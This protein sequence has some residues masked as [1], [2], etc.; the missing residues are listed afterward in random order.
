MSPSLLEAPLSE[1]EDSDFEA[2]PIAF[3]DVV[4]R[5]NTAETSMKLENSSED[6]KQRHGGG[7]IVAKDTWALSDSGISETDSEYSSDSS[8]TESEASDFLRGIKR[9]EIDGD[10]DGPLENESESEIP[11]RAR[12]FPVRRLDNDH[13]KRDEIAKAKIKHVTDYGTSNEVQWSK[14]WEVIAKGHGVTGSVEAISQ[15]LEQAGI[16]DGDRLDAK[17]R[18]TPKSDQG[19]PLAPRKPSF[20]I[21]KS[22][23]QNSSFS[24]VKLSPRDLELMMVAFRCWKNQRGFQVGSNPSTPYGSNVLRRLP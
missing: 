24:T 6:G 1:L 15:A 20:Q 22:S 10:V 19:A 11:D 7:E 21:S 18:A 2:A 16:P 8:D 17:P 3:S 14:P 9:E 23:T 5:G 13:G 12:D 4:G